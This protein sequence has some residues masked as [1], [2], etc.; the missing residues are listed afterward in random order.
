MAE[1]SADMKD[2][3]A[4]LTTFDCVVDV[5]TAQPIHGLVYP[6]CCH[7]QCSPMEQGSTNKSTLTK[8]MLTPGKQI[9]SIYAGWV[10]TDDFMDERATKDDHLVYIVPSFVGPKDLW[11]NSQGRLSWVSGFRSVQVCTTRLDRAWVSL[12]LMVLCYSSS[13][14]F[15]D[16]LSTRRCR[17]V[18]IKFVRLLE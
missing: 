9:I 1:Q 10:I 12:S 11:F 2:T 15:F 14:I 6:Y 13:Q 3:P 5:R 4:G 7:T 17:K 16:L 8:F 18:G